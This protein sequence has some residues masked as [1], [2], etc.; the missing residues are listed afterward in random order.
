VKNN[1]EPHKYF[2]AQKE[3]ETFKEARQDIFKESSAS[4]SVAKE[5]QDPP[6][7]EISS[8]MDHTSKG[9]PLE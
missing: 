7:Y 4:T 6:M 8:S 5:I 1:T 9:K 3:N 2:D